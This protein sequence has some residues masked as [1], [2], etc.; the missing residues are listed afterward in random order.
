MKKIL[1]ILFSTLILASCGGEQKP[2]AT[3]DTSETAKEFETPNSVA[4]VSGTIERLW[5]ATADGEGGIILAQPPKDI[6]LHIN[7]K[8]GNLA[9]NTEV[10]D[11]FKYKSPG[12]KPNAKYLGKKVKITYYTAPA[13]GQAPSQKRKAHHITK[14]EVLGDES[15]NPPS[16]EYIGFVTGVIKGDSVCITL[17]KNIDEPGVETLRLYIDEE[18]YYKVNLDGAK[19]IF[20]YDN[21]SIQLNP[22]HVNKKIKVT[23]EM[24]PLINKMVNQG[25]WSEVFKEYAVTKI[26]WAD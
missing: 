2:D 12:Y 1:Y 6:E 7:L 11:I 21:Y 25:N 13:P 17:Q 8:D 16:K 15:Q 10:S 9:I 23:C 3:N 20:T 19:D 22:K 5:W 18:N 26:E 4:I 14:I 24:K